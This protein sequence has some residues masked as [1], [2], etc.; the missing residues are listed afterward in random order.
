L[1]KN[2]DRAIFAS[3]CFWGTE[4]YLAQAV[5]VISTTVGFTGGSVANPTYKQVCS[6]ETGHAE[7]IEII[8]DPKETTYE[9]LAKLFFETH[10]P[11]Q[12]NRQGPDVG[13]QYRSEVFYVDDHQKDVA[14]RLIEEL[15]AKG[16]PV[17]TKVTQ[18]AMFWPAEENHQ[19]YYEK[20]GQLP[21]CHVYTPRF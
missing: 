18:A 11:T 16:Y 8:F 2:T 15:K 19:D 20:N 3:G 4:Y 5:G 13:D 17:S 6:E 1:E 14:E 7:A 12:I 9:S 10:D 21:Y